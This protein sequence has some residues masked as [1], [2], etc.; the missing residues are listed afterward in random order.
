MA[1]PEHPDQEPRRPLRGQ[2]PRPL[3]AVLGGLFAAGSAGA[4]MAY[5]RFAWQV[6]TLP[7]RVMEWL[8][9]YVPPALFEAGIQRFGFDAKRYALA[10]AVAGMLVALAAVGAVALHRQRAVWTLLGL[11]LGLWLFT[12]LVVLPVTGAGFFALDLLSGTSAAVGGYLAVAL[13][14]ATALALAQLAMQATTPAPGAA[15][16]APGT[17]A[18]PSP[19]GAFGAGRRAAFALAGAAATAFGATGATVRWG[20]RPTLPRAMVPDPQQPFPSG[21]VEALRPHPTVMS[22]R[23]PEPP[24]PAGTRLAAPSIFEPAPARRLARGTDG[25]LLAAARQA[26]ELAPALTP[27]GSFYVVTKNAAG[28]PQLDGREWVLRV[29]GEVERPVELDLMEVRRLPAVEVVKTLEC[30][31]N[32]T[33]KCELVPFGCDLISTARWTGARVA[34][35]IALAG[36]PKPGAT[37]L[38][39]FAADEFTTSL[40]L[41]VAMAPDTLLAYEMNGQVLAREHGYP[42]RMLVPGRYGM[43]NAKWVVALRLLNREYVDWYGQRGWSKDGLVKTMCRIDLPAPGAALPTGWHRI[44][45]I[46]YAGDRGIAY[47]EYSADGGRTWSVADFLERPPGRDV[48]VRW[49]GEFVV[50]RGAEITLVARATDGM[51]ETQPEPFTLPQP[52]GGSGWPSITIHGA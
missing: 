7:E 20:P 33:A 24:A 48:W 6:R 5:L 29:D 42:A 39:T 9:L 23:E 10:G 36:G 49:E 11:A 19:D 4:G 22:G 38:V 41:P 43:K 2:L 26:G 28:D 14:Y 37:T 35:L 27:I 44:A 3:L 8:L 30:I 15:A 25:A 18:T 31:S 34:D 40:P 17:D 47:V 52:D 32:F 51:G 16:V 21:G 12:M 13:V 45:G 50:T 1:N 46:A